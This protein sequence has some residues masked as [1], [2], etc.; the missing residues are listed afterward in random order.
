MEGSKRHAT[1]SE[2]TDVVLRG[3]LPLD[4]ILNGLLDSSTDLLHDRGQDD[5]RILGIGLVPIRV[6]ANDQRLAVSL[7]SGRSAH[8][9]RTGDGHDDVSTLRDELLRLLQPQRLVIEG[10]C[11]GSRL[12]F[13]VPAKH[14][15][16][17]SLRLVVGFH[18]VRKSVHK[19]SHGGDLRTT[20]GRD[21]TGL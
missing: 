3:E 8:S 6:D 18:T 12:G 16:G 5:R 21:L 11:E 13:L 19:H 10:I 20:E 4:R 1:I 17:G 15:H 7:R 2:R 14:L 9:D